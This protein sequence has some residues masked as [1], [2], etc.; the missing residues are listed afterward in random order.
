V[1]DSYL[2]SDHFQNAV[3]QGS[4]P[5]LILNG[6]QMIF[7]ALYIHDEVLILSGFTALLRGKSCQLEDFLL[8][9]G[10]GIGV[11]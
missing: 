7:S 9:N 10:Y 4:S 6:D 2:F 3:L 1:V 11:V 8:G 5:I